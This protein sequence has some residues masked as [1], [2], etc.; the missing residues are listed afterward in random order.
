MLTK[1]GIGTA[2]ACAIALGASSGAALATTINVDGVHWDSASPFDLTIQTLNLRES[3]VSAVGDVLTGYGQIGSING[4]NSFC[5]GCDLTFTFAYTVTGI[6]ANHVTFDDGSFQFYVS[7]AGSYSQANPN[8]ATLGTPWVTMA[9]HTAPS[10]DPSFIT[11]GQLYG[12]VNGT[13]SN[14]TSGSDGIGLV[15]VL[16]G[17][18]AAYLNSNTISDGIGGFA[19]FSLNSSFLTKPASTCTSISP[20]SGSVCHFPIEGNGSLIGATVGPEPAELGLMGLGLGF[21]GF[22][23]QRRRKAA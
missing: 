1:K 5:T 13:V 3:S 2:L 19:D 12:T 20:D 6:S 7:P 8:S 14:P 22:L 17:P 21:L 9:G 18:A 11:V 10:A 23:I 16:G 15:D 4:I